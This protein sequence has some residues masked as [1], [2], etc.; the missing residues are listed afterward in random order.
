MGKIEV[1]AKAMPILSVVG[2]GLFVYVGSGRQFID[3]LFPSLASAEDNV[4]A[5][6]VLLPAAFLITITVSL[7]L[8]LIQKYVLK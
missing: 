5:L 6:M 3:N 1:I 8:G 4:V 7:I 2:V